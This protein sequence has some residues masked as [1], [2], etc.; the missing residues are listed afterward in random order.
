MDIMARYKVGIFVIAA[1]VAAELHRAMQ[2]AKSISLTAKNARA[3]AVR[4]GEKSV[5]F[6]AITNF[7]D[8]LAYNTIRQARTINDVAVFVSRIA[9][10]HRR[11]LDTQSR[12]AIVESM[13][14]SSA[15]V[16]SIA[17]AQHELTVLVNDYEEQMKRFFFQLDTELEE[18]EKHIRA[19][20]IIATTSKVEASGAGEFR[21]QLDVIAESIQNNASQIKTHLKKARQLLQQVKEISA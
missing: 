3:I 5:G 16:S 14:Q 6:K 18:T 9:V 20:D 15:F 12:L 11:A 13:G 4:A 17:P 7:I 10:L 19:A 2:V 21:Q 1:S 8:E